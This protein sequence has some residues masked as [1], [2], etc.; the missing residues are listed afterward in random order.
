MAVLSEVHRSYLLVVVIEHADT[1]LRE[2]DVLKLLLDGCVAAG[3]AVLNALLTVSVQ[4]EN[5]GDL[6]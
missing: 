3:H 4:V 5:R 2:L 1:L 6:K